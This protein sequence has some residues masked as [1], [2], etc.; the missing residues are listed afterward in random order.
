MKLLQINEKEKEKYKLQNDLIFVIDTEGL[1]APE[2]FNSEDSEK[3]DNELAALAVGLGNVTMVN[4][5]GENMSDIKDILQIVVLALIRMK[6][7]HEDLFS[8]IVRNACMFL[9]Q[10]V[11]AINAEEK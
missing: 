8:P 7:A 10:N 3:R 5:F 11:S 2:L 1:R 9:H 4:M 6:I